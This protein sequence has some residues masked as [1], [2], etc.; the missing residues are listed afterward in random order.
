[1]NK[2]SLRRLLV[3]AICAA[4]SWLPSTG[5]PLRAQTGVLG[6]HNDPASTGQNLSE[7]KITPSLVN[8]NSFGKI[9]AAAVDGQVYA[10]PLYVPALPIT[11]GTYAGTTHSVALVATQHDSVYAI[12]AVSGAEIWKLSLINAA[13]GETA[14]PA[15][16]N[17]Q[18]ENVTGSIDINPEVG[19][20]GTPVID[21]TPDANG[22]RYLY[23]AAKSRL[24]VSG[25]P[26]YFFKLHAI[27]IAS[28]TERNGSP[29]V[30]AENTSVYD[31]GTNTY[32]YAYLSG[33]SVA[34]TGDG[35]VNGRVNFN[36]HREHQ[37]PALTL[38][39]GRV[40]LAFASHGDNGPYH[41]WVLGYDAATLALKAVFNT[42]P[43]GSDGGIW[44]SGGRISVDAAGALYVSTGNGTFANNGT[45]VVGDFDANGL[46][47]KGN[48][49]D[50]ILKLVA[51]ASTTASNPHVNGWGLRVADYFTPYNQANLSGGDT[52]LGSSGI[53]LLPDSVGS[54]AHPRLLVT[55][56]KEG[57]I[58]LVDR[59]NMGRFRGGITG[60]GAARAF[61]T[62]GDAVVQQKP[63]AFVSCF[64]SPAYFNGQ[65]YYAGNRNDLGKAF[66]IANGV[67]ADTPASVTAT[68]FGGFGPTFSVSASG[69]ATNGV[70]WG[71]EKD[72]GQLRAYGAASFAN[73]LYTS[74]QAANNRD[75]LGNAVKF[76]VPTVADG[77]VL[78]GTSVAAGPSTLVAFGVFGQY[79]GPPAQPLNLF[80]Q[81][82][83]GGEIDLFWDDTADNESGYEVYVS[84]DPN[85]FPA[86]PR[87]TT[88]AS[89]S[90]CAIN[91]LQLNTTYHF[92]VRAIN[93]VGNSAY[94]NTAATTSGEAPPVNF[95]NGFA[96]SESL[97]SGQN[98][99]TT[100]PPGI[101][102][103]VL[104]VTDA[105]N[106]G[107]RAVW[108]NTAQDV[109]KFTTVFDFQD[110]NLAGKKATGDG[111]MFVIQ[112]TGLTAR[113]GGGSGLGYSGIGRSVGIKF[114]LFAS[115][116]TPADS[117]STTGYYLN[118]A[119][120]DDTAAPNLPATSGAIDVLTNNGL[121][122]HNGHVFRVVVTYDGAKLSWTITD[123]ATRASFASQPYPLNIPG[124][125]AGGPAPANT[126]YIGFTGGQG[127]SKAIQDIIS[128]SY[129]PS[130]P[131]APAA[132]SAL[133]GVG[134]SATQINLS[135]T[136]NA[137][138]ETGFRVERAPGASGGTFAPVGSVGAN[139]TV[140]IDATLSTNTTYSYRVVATNAGLSSGASNVVT[141]TTPVPPNTPSG[142]HATRVTSNEI[143]F[144][145][146][147]N[148]DNETGFRILRSNNNGEYFTLVTLPPNSTGYQDATVQPDTIYSYHIQAYNAAGYVDFTG[149]NT[150]TLSGVN[151]VA[152]SATAQ[153][154]TDTVGTFA[155]R[156]PSATGNP[157]TV[158]YTIQTS[159]GQAAYNTR[160]TLSPAPTTTT[161]GSIVIP[162]NT[163]AATITVTPAADETLVGPQTVTL[164][165]AP[166]EGYSAAGSAA[167]T[168]T[169]L[170]TP[171]NTWKI[172][173]FGSL[174][175]AQSP[176][177]ADTADYDNDGVANL[178]EYALG[179][180]A[181]RPGDANRPAAAVEAVDG[182]TYLT[183]TFKRPAPAPAGITYAVESSTS[184]TGAPTWQAGV[185]VPGYPVNNGNGVETLKVRAAT[186]VS[187]SAQGFIRLRVTRSGG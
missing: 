69:P 146:S 121:D 110:T 140:F 123:T 97:F 150:T 17:G 117:A 94:S 37:R 86:T 158:N 83:S 7:Q 178:V 43:N 130:L 40:Y 63:N 120:P 52:D 105:G 179:N 42:T 65:F 88:S 168:V 74:D 156:R 59:D 173:Q 128:L 78:I 138:N 76:G 15:N 91:G 136:D 103:N 147:D 100:P 2:R 85:N 149:F 81:T 163:T 166:G 60:T 68:G 26:H 144:E 93:F 84:T 34:G 174:A 66:S 61:V 184:L 125:V 127:G 23:V 119:G 95:T 64:S 148:S 98:F 51:D 154:S 20:T 164:A 50:S 12:D 22:K 89:A 161:T 32:T 19:V 24:V 116:N 129:T 14:V 124:L 106:D 47:I 176:Q 4:A 54:A 162:A 132:P 139:T 152:S 3:V 18:G 11:A 21:A 27:D 122:F 38:S 75:R 71:I 107:T 182:G 114:D 183:L 126:A 57:R 104:R 134:A 142:A 157:L 101:T 90:S 6:F 92:R 170:D 160:Y 113:G 145:W 112:N 5:S 77:H 36:A 135:W 96:G 55:A 48:Y 165:L 10:Q 186:P 46:P 31:A 133:G 58:Y 115:T 180:N 13:G 118:G 35:A 70:L 44:M 111:L 177:A 8:T 72:A 99:T 33:P 167:A 172:E 108:L 187:A 155:V 73:L 62:T 53:L 181:A 109:R 67:F 49:G 171:I 82:V 153:E 131:V 185:T 39:G 80:A 9:F 45:Q 102:G 143:D 56:G 79:A 87:L 169:I 30:V 151:I 141:L 41:G 175:A 1:M 29:V 25:V 28:G 137:T 159:A 16:L